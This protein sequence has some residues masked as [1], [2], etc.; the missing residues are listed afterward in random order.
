MSSLLVLDQGSTA[1]KGALLDR[2]GRIVAQ[3][4]V[5]VDTRAEG[6]RVELDAEALLAGVLQVLER[7]AREGEPD[8]LALACQRSTCLLW[9]REGGR[10]LTPA[11]SWQDRRE[12]AR[13]ERLAHGSE[14]VARLTGLRLSPHYAAPKLAGL[15]EAHPDP[16]RRAAAGEVLAGTLDAWLVQRLTGRP[17]TEPGHAGRTL[18]YDLETD[19]W[20]TELTDLWGIAEA[21]LPSLLPSRQ[22][23]GTWH[24]IPLVAVLGDQQAALLGHGGWTAGTCAVHFGTGAFVLL[25]TGTRILRHQGLLS[26]VLASTSAERH[27]GRHSGRHF[28]LE[29]SINSAGS[30]VDAAVERTGEILEAWRDRPLPDT[31]VPLV[32]PALAGLA[33]PW[34]RADVSGLVPEGDELPKGPELLAAVLAGLAHR[35]GDIVEAMGDAGE[36]PTRLRT[37]GKLTRLAGLMQQLADVTGV[38]V[39]VAEEEEAGLVGLFHLARGSMAEPPAQPARSFEPQWRST[40]REEERRRWR[41]FLRDRASV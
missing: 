16:A 25:G 14:T 4:E 28:Q 38:P 23:R 9:E 7:C 24:G 15:L 21:S 37:S 18:L 10:P 27:S 33:A 1:T 22:E 12:A 41:R 6:E 8:A 29:G 3:E 36:V 13:V 31:G 40:H 34:W 35:V 19:R 17:S 11:L 2:R 30:A 26:A 39:E 32:L 5:P 20:S